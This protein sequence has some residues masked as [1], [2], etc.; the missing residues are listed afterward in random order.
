[1]N[2]YLEKKEEVI[3]NPEGE[4]FLS[5]QELLQRG[6]QFDKLVNKC[7]FVTEGYFIINTDITFEINLGVIKTPNDII[8]WIRYLT[9]KNWVDN[10]IIQKFIRAAGNKLNLEEWWVES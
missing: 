6:S 8:A 3:F 7:V 10:H 2:T 1:M 4:F 5:F 9:D